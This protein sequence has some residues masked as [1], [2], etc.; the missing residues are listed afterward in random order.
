MPDNNK[1][2]YVFVPG[3]EQ[4]RVVDAATFESNKDKLYAQYPN[5]EVAEMTGYNPEDTDLNDRDQYQVMVPGMVSPTTVD[6]KTFNNRR[7]ELFKQYPDAQ[8]TRIRDYSDGYWRPKLE[9]AQ[10]ALADF[11]IQHGKTMNDYETFEMLAKNSEQGEIPNFN[12]PAHQWLREHDAEYQPLKKQRDALRSAI[13]NNPLENKGRK[14]AYEQAMAASDSFMKLA[15]QAESGAERRDYKRAA[16]LQ[17]DAAKMWSAPGEYDQL[18]D[19]ENG[20]SKYME[21]YKKGA[22]KTFSDKDFWTRGLTQ[23]AR[24]IDL[25]GIRKKIQ[26]AEKVKGGPLDEGDYDR[27]ITPSEKAQLFSFYELARAQAKRAN[28]LSSAYKAGESAAE[29]L[30]FMAEFLLS[31][32]LANVAGKALSASSNGFARWM[33]QALM[34][35]KALNRAVAKGVTTIPQMSRVAKVGTELARPVVQGLWHTT[36]Q[37]STLSNMAQMMNQTNDEGELNSVG[38]GIWLGFADSLVENWSESV[39]NNI[40]KG[41]GLVGEGIANIG[42]KT[43]GKTTFGQMARWALHSPF[44]LTLKEAGFNGFFGEMLEEWAGNAVRLATGLMDGDEFKQFA[45]VQQQ[46][47][48]AASFAPMSLFGLAGNTVSSF[49]NKSEYERLAEKTKGILMRNGVSQAEIDA[50]F[51]KKWATSEDIAAG[52]APYAQQIINSDSQTAK[53]DYKTVLELAQMAGAKSFNEAVEGIVSEQERSQMK[54]V[55]VAQMGQNFWQDYDSPTAVEEDGTPVQIHKVRVVDYADGTHRYIVGGYGIGENGN[56]SYATID[57]NG[58]YG[59]ISDSEIAQGMEAG[60]ITADRE[61]MLDDYLQER[62]DAAK[63]SVESKRLQHELQQNY[64]ALQQRVLADPKIDIGTPEHPVIATVV[65][66]LISNKGVLVQYEH[67]GQLVNRSMTWS[68]VATYLNMP[69]QGKTDAQL[70]EEAAIEQQKAE[71]RKEKYNKI[72]PGT[73]VT[74][75]MDMG[76]E[77]PIAAPYRFAKA[78]F[79]ANEGIVRIYMQDENGQAVTNEKGEE[80]WFPEDMVQGLDAISEQA[81]QEANVE[82]APAEEPVVEEAQPAVTRYTGKDGRVNQTSFI[83]NEPEEWAKWNDARRQDNG[84]NTMQRL[85]AAIAELDANITKSQKEWEKESNP[86]EADKK[87]EA[88]N[89]LKER[90]ERL[91][92]ILQTYVA[93]RKAIKEAEDAAQR[94]AFKKEVDKKKEAEKAVR[95]KIQDD[96]QADTDFVAQAER[97][98]GEKKTVGA[99]ETINVQGRKYTGHWVVSEVTTPK[100]SH[101]PLNDYAPTPGYPIGKAGNTNHYDKDKRAQQITQEMADHY[102]ERAVQEAVMVTKHGI[103]ISG[104]GRTQAAL[105]AA[106]QGTDAAYQE[107]IRT[108]PYKWGLTAEQINEYEHPFIYFELDEDVEY[109]AALF[110]AFNRSTSKQQGVVETATKVAQMTSDELIMRLDR[111][112]REVGDSLDSLYNNPQKVNELLNILQEAGLFNANE[113]ARYVNEGGELNGAGEDLVN[114]VLFGTIF[115]SSDQAIRDAMADK[116]IG[117]AIAYAFPTLVRIRNLSGEYSIIEELTQAVSLLARAKESNKGKAEGAIEDYMNQYSLFSEGLPVEKATVQLLAHVL[118]SKKY[119][120]LRSVLDQYIDRAE[121]ASNGQMDMFTGDVEAKE[122]IVRDVLDYNNIKIETYDNSGTPA[123]AEMAPAAP[124]QG[125]IGSG[126]QPEG[127]GAAPAAQSSGNSAPVDTSN[128]LDVAAKVAAVNRRLEKWKKFLGDIFVVHT[129]TSTVEDAA[130]LAEIQKQDAAVAAGESRDD[131]AVRGWF[132]PNT[133]KAHI[134]LPHL[135]EMSN[136][137]RNLDQTILHEVISHKG[138]RALFN[139]KG[140]GEFNKFLDWAWDNLMSDEAKSFFLEYVHGSAYDEASRRAAAD[141][142]FAHAAESNQAILKQMDET[143][144]TR[145][146]DALKNFIN[147]AVGEDL[148]TDE[149]MDWFSQLLQSAMMAVKEGAKPIQQEDS[150]SL[151][152]KL[153]AQG[154]PINADGSLI[155]DAIESIEQLTDEDFTAPTR[156]VILPQ[157]PSNVDAAIGADGKPVIIKKNIF[158]R[159]AERHKDLTPEQSRDIL[160]NALYNAQLYGQNQPVSRPYNWVV[161]NIT[162]ADGLNKTVLLEIDETKN[163]VEIVHWHYV[164][165]RGLNKIKRQARREGGRILMLP[166]EI[167]EEAGALSGRTSGLSSESKGTDNNSIPQETSKISNETEEGNILLSVKDG[168]GGKSLVGIH[169]ISARKLAA[170]LETGGLANPSM[171]V[172]DLGFQIHEDYGDISLIAPASLIDSETGNNAGTFNG[173]AWT[174]TYPGVTKQMS[175]KGWDKFYDD[176]RVLPEPFSHQV[177]NDWREH[178]EDDRMG[179]SLYW[180]FLQETGKN[181][182]TIYN[183]TNLSEEDKEFIRSL[184]GKRIF[185]DDES[186]AKAIDLYRRLAPEEDVARAGRKVEIK[187]G[188]AGRYRDYMI[189]RNEDIDAWGIWTVPVVDLIENLQRQVRYEGTIAEQATYQAAVDFVTNNKLEEEFQQWV[190]DKEKKYGTKSVLFAGWTPDGDRKYVPNTVENAS[191]LMNKEPE[192]NAYG[193]GGLSATRSL[194]L[195]RMDT[196]EDIR[197]HR[198]ELADIR[199]YASDT[200]EYEQARD[201]WFDVI[202]ALANMQKISDNE[203]SNIDYAEARLQEAILEKRPIAYLNREYR[204]SIP[205]DG[206]F[207]EALKASIKE[208]KELPAKYFETKFNR[209]VYLNEFAASVIPTDTPEN[210][211]KALEEAG[212]PAY[213]YD[214]KVEGARQEAVLKASEA[215]GIRFSVSRFSPEVVAEMSSIREAAEKAGTFMKAPN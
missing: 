192:Q 113:R 117:R 154:N 43:L 66:D 106:T 34:S 165:N 10:A 5:A 208:I 109:T 26:E 103:V 131:H 128:P 100:P 71:Q 178:I 17:R 25:Y 153:D 11:D 157:L 18:S 156:S 48:M 127:T 49:R 155:A 148:F 41:F 186:A 63:K 132:D 136:Q 161:I 15:E 123:N 181:P 69:L 211:R 198:S 205:E 29:S 189:A 57:D 32:G 21:D 124:E 122:R 35:E 80:V 162:G 7:E 118:N 85:S 120:S 194:L 99:K 50:L 160:F 97:Y 147:D 104:N 146:A 177:R 82:E 174:P 125:G 114:S 133:G 2:Y 173:D 134:Y 141:E 74:V 14:Q 55:M 59:Y 213:E 171:A 94:E 135:L 183:T 191:R 54:D 28:D 36:T 150:G 152:S 1:Q 56:K 149:D 168:K 87:E 214:D 84:D 169:N 111:L 207:A 95:A 204:Y 142:F 75:M 196:L 6:S 172:I 93:E 129:D 139:L 143:F 42:T 9:E 164:D 92:S 78:I 101:N 176:V 170:A 102:D 115:S 73:P 145:L 61:L 167:T 79:D 137:Q 45:S 193:N 110:D 86:D 112:F 8:V 195:R 158:E 62:V 105:L 166:S 151:F 64:A 27:L 190:Q 24:D 126:A 67:E 88:L 202:E 38:R 37:L 72:Q 159:N 203:F 108:Y 107:Y 39:G 210:V 44:A 98:A 22:G 20:F 96:L 46:L 90:R 188:R 65:T 182:E 77:A 119:A 70:T 68:E 76:G 197:K 58:Q 199:G 209:P 91:N 23:I 163:N 53:A 180:W 12:S 40:E 16:K 30:G 144:W 33:G 206:E 47:E 31:Q 13:Y 51:N 138:L 19:G 215:D 187:E 121:A 201:N 130:A 83:K 175:E 60:N 179:R 3:E 116:S 89:A 52:L 140:E 81:Q 4:G 200:P 184:S 212:V 185:G